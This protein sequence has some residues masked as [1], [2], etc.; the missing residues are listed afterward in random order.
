M[1]NVFVNVDLMI[2]LAKN[3]KPKEKTIYDATRHPLL[4]ITRDFMSRVFDLDI[5]LDEN[6]DPTLLANE[7]VRP[8]EIYK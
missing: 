3:Y 1:L 7:Y 2:S 6:I 4:L 5:T 8:K